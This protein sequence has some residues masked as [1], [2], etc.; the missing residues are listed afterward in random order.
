MTTFTEGLTCWAKY[1]CRNSSLWMSPDSDYMIKLL[2]ALDEIEML[3]NKPE[4]L[5]WL[6]S[7]PAIKQLD[8][9]LPAKDKETWATKMD[10]LEARPRSNS[11]RS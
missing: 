3:L 8:D 6:T 7:K 11:R 2:T 10:S 5:E 9:K 4:Q 1:S